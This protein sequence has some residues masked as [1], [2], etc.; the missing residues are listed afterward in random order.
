MKLMFV[1]TLTKTR[2]CPDSFTAFAA[3]STGP[4]YRQAQARTA[5]APPH[6]G[7]PSVTTKITA[8]DLRYLVDDDAEVAGILRRADTGGRWVRQ[9][10]EQDQPTLRRLAAASSARLGT[11]LAPLDNT[12]AG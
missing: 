2:R 8:G 5:P 10:E 7:S 11:P 4:E 6:V 12:R 3:S 1:P 9:L